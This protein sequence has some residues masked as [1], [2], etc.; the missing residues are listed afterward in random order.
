MV[1]QV[2]IHDKKIVDNAKLYFLILLN[3]Y[4][5]LFKQVPLYDGNIVDSIYSTNGF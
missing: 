2:P 5:T 1:K 3:K 4:E